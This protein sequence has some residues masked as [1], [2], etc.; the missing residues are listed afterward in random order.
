MS[1]QFERVYSGRPGCMCGCRGNYSSHKSSITRVVNKILSSPD[2][3]REDNHVYLDTPT[4][5][6]VAFLK[7]AA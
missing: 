5:T 4:R 3:K 6:Y 7:E 2:H 1:E